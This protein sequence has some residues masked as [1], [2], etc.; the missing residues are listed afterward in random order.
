MIEEFLHFLI[1]EKGLS[2]N[3]IESYGRDLLLFRRF[4][5]GEKAI[6]S[7][8]DIATLDGDHLFSFLQDL[9]NKGYASSS[10]GRMI[11]SIKLF[12]RFLKK[13]QKIAKDIASCLDLPKVAYLLPEILTMQEV[14]KL[15][16]AISNQDFL[17]ARD[18]AIIETL[19]ATGMRVSE[20]CE[21]NL[22]DIHDDFIKVFG[23]GRKERL[24]PL[25][26]KAMLAIDHFLLHF[27]GKALEEKAPL[28]TSIR[29]K[30]MDRVTVWKRVQFWIEKAGIQKKVSPHTFRHSFATHLLE[31]GAD[32]RVIQELLG[33]EEIGTTDRYTQ[34]RSDLVK[35]AFE[36][37]HPRP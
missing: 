22:S 34:L 23:K 24:V 10:M 28:F 3:T 26:K 35:K 36:K 1:L 19:Y 30:R 21:C 4:F 9:K 13:E 37:F 15:L 20:L 31:N 5:F 7:E 33:H 8:E 32:L 14:E 6:L 18:L 29:G 17:G 2:K 11:V 25:G 12:F 16:G 27:R